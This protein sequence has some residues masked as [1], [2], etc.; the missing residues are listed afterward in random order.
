MVLRT[1]GGSPARAAPSIR[2][3]LLIA[4]EGGFVLGS[5]HSSLAERLSLGEPA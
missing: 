1:D 5:G 4:S 3:V 2:C